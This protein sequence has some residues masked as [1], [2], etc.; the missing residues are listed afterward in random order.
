MLRSCHIVEM[1]NNKIKACCQLELAP[2][3]RLVIDYI[4]S[5][6]QSDKNSK[7]FYVSSKI[8]YTL[9]TDPLLGVVHKY[10][11]TKLYRLAY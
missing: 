6:I 7:V 1:S 4:I 3:V 2:R 11:P 5:F 8:Y 9:L 10:W